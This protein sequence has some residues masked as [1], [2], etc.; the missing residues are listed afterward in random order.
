MI[1]RTIDISDQAYLHLKHRQLLIDK[2]GENVAQIPIED[3]GALIL[4]NPAIVITQAAVIACQKN[5]VALVFC[6]E[7]YLPY[8]LLLP[9][10]DGNTLHTK[11]LQQQI[12]LKL[13]TKKR[14]WG[15]IVT[16]KLANQAETLKH[17]DKTFLPLEHLAN[18]VKTGDPDNLEAQ[19]AQKYWRLLFGE[20]FRRDAELDGINS[21]LNYGYAIIRALIARAIVGSGLHPALGLY[22][23]N[24]YNGLCLADDL[25][26]PF[27]PWVDFEVYNMAK[28][29]PE[30]AVIKDSKMP[31]LQLLSEP[32]VWDGQTLPLMVA[33]HYLLANLKRAYEDSAVMLR[34]P[35]RLIGSRKPAPRKEENQ[36]EE[37]D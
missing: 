16:Q 35:Q 30:L 12:S 34:Y 23:S 21:L 9:I 4:Q 26:E 11:I 19:G 37:D 22:H 24:Q 28:A 13:P 14:L 3:I 15:Q 6:D 10:S 29:N 7:K 36:G 2:K 1:K 31:L 5:N 8:S 27:R 18:Q 25:M 20:Q 33:C 17:L 32:V